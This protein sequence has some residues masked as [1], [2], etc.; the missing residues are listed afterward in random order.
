MTR[1]SFLAAAATLGLA[2]CQQPT[3]TA[4]QNQP[5]T[6]LDVPD[7]PGVDNLG[8]A[9]ASGVPTAAVFAETAAGSNLF[10]I[11]SGKLGE[12]KGAS[13]DVRGFGAMLA[14]EHEKSMNEL[15][16]ALAGMQPQVMLPSSPPPELQAKLQALQGLS[17]EAFDR[18]FIADQIAVHQQSLTALNAYVA[19]GD[20]AALRN[21]ASRATGVVQK[22]LQ[23]LNRMGQP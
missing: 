3:T 15:K 18:Q 14:A 11:S 9:A 10:E 23:Q 1:L 2:A 4:S 16:A 7:E 5:Q 17:G 8:A 22:H 12:E 6:Q 13:G 19:G 21:W 20:N